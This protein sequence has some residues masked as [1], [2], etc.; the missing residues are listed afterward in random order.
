[1]NVTMKLRGLTLAGA[2]TA[3]LVASASAIPIATTEGIINSTPGTVTFGEVAQYLSGGTGLVGHD[4]VWP[5]GPSDVVAG[6]N[7]DHFWVQGVDDNPV[8]FSFSRPQTLV[9]GF[10][11]IDHPPVPEESLEWILWGSND[12]GTWEEGKI[13]AIYDDGWD[14]T[15]SADGH[16]DDWSSLW[17]FTTGYQYVMATTHSHLVPDYYDGDYEIDGVAAVPEPRTLLLLGLGVVAI[18]LFRRTMV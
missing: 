15:N 3:G 7:I 2:M 4:G 14:S 10:A 18:G 6:S 1:M 16:S 13:R 9:L 17:G 5:D 8:I 11:G 12:L